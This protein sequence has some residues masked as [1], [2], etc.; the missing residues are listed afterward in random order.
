MVLLEGIE[1]LYLGVS[2]CI[3]ISQKPKLST[4]F[5]RHG[6]SRHTAPYYI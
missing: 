4:L 6:T 2:W 3:A 5:V 1:I